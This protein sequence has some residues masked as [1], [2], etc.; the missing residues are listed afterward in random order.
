MSKNEDTIEEISK[1]AGEKTEIS[2]S[3][4]EQHGD[5]DNSISKNAESIRLISP[6]RLRQFIEGEQL[7][8]RS[9]HRQD[10]ERNKVRP[11][12]IFNTKDTVMPYRYQFLSRWIDTDKELNEI[13][14]PSK[15]AML[16]L[17][18]LTV[19]FAPFIRNEKERRAYEG[20]NSDM[21]KEKQGKENIR[22]TTNL[23]VQV[24]Q[25]QTKRSLKM[26]RP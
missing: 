11:Y 8:I 21:K 4:N 16:S 14:I 3:S 24:D 26:I 7:I 22:W 1:Q 17:E 19:D 15:H 23:K 25:T 5:L 20:K 10:L 12:P 13:D 2:I 6:T 9:L 18:E